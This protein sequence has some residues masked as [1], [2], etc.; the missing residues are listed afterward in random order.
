MVLA[1]KISEWFGNLDFKN[2][3]MVNIIVWVI[4]AVIILIV[5]SGGKKDKPVP[6]IDPQGGAMISD[7]TKYRQSLEKDMAAALSA[8]DGA[9]AVQVTLLLENGGEKFIA[10]DVKLNEERNSEDAVDTEG[11]SSYRVSRDDK[12]VIT[13]KQNQAGQPI[14]L[15]ENMPKISGVLVAAKGAG[16]EKV[17]LELYEAAKAISGAYV[18]RIKVVALK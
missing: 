4:I 16:D 3:K 12:V 5:M 15:K 7:I 2:K 18:H 10:S 8:I 13:S 9:G 14:L 11:K 6:I 17:K 1:F